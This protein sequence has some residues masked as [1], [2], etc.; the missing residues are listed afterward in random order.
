M[1]AFA[2]SVHSPPPPPKQTVYDA[3]CRLV[4][5]WRRYFGHFESARH[6]FLVSPKHSRAAAIAQ[7]APPAVPLSISGAL[8]STSAAD[9]YL[10]KVLNSALFPFF[11]YLIV[12]CFVRYHLLQSSVGVTFYRGRQRS[13]HR[14]AVSKCARSAVGRRLSVW[15]SALALCIGSSLAQRWDS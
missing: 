13:V 8:P 2:S 15:L 3:V 6:F 12:A 5:L 10:K 14:T 7:T 4:D 11:T 9:I 1:C